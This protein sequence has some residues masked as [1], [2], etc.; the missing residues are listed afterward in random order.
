MAKGVL[1]AWAESVGT[2]VNEIAGFRFTRLTAQ[3]ALGD[4]VF[5]VETTFGWPSSGRVVCDGTVFTYAAKTATSLTGIRWDDQAQRE[6]AADDLNAVNEQVLVSLSG[7]SVVQVVLSG[8]WVGTI[9]LEQGDSV[10][11]WTTVATYNANA[12]AEVVVP[13]GSQARLRVSAYTSGTAAASLVVV[14]RSGAK[15]KV[16]SM[17]A[18]L[19]YSRTFSALDAVRSELFVDTA[20]GPLLD[21]LGRNLGVDRPPNLVDDDVFRR[22]IKA[23]A[24]LPKGT[25]F[26]LETALTA[27]FG[28]GNFE[29]W[30]DFPTFRNTVFIRLL[31]GVN[32]ATSATGQ[33]YLMRRERRPLNV[34]AMQV[35]V[36]GPVLAVQGAR[37]ADE[38]SS[39]LQL[40]TGP[41]PEV[42]TTAKPS[43]LTE[44]RYSG[45]AGAAVW[46]FTGTTEGDVTTN[47]GNGLLFTP[48][49]GDT[50]HYGRT[51]RIRPESDARMS[52]R[53]RVNSALASG[54]AD[55]KQLNM[56]IR[57]GTRNICVGVIGDGGSGFQIG[58]VNFATGQFLGTVSPAIYQVGDWLDVEIKRPP[59]GRAELWV[60][61]ALRQHEAVSSFQST[62]LNEFRF[63]CQD[64]NYTQDI[65][66]RSVGFY[67]RTLTDYWNVF[68]SGAAVSSGTPAQ[69]DTNSGLMLLADD[70]KFIRTVGTGPNTGL[71]RVAGFVDTD[72]VDLTADFKPRAFVQS[73]FPTR[74]TVANAPEAFSYPQDVGKKLELAGGVAAGTYLITAVL[75]PVSAVALSGSF[76]EHSNMVE[77]TSIAPP[78]PPPFVTEV[79]LDWR[80][81]PN[82][83]TESGVYWELAG[84]GSFSGLTLTLR[85]NPP[86]DIPGGY[87]V[88]LEPVY[89]TVKSG[90][91]LTET[92]ANSPVDSFF[93]FY[94]PQHPFGPF[95]QYLDDLTVAG[96][97]PE[98]VL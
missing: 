33:T 16:R 93:P 88:I 58:F 3:L 73:A 59:G 64:V 60:N 57:D 81:L 10:S 65:N 74:V 94:L 50:A 71:W 11:G 7:P 6:T 9:L 49:I 82:F 62:T 38:D 63:G 31:N 77:V 2:A 87:V 84:A 15:K 44:T 48:G 4:A 54:A 40:L 96:V 14:A 51:A 61:G 52:M 78:T 92:E 80:V 95:A 22:V 98:V 91:L 85:A 75:D 30:E 20:E 28:A 23:M 13:A 97:I 55:G 29:I 8:T 17:T 42:F 12:S 39:T 41:H 46:V 90:Q 26:G 36:D 34:G 24:Y 1:E 66:I 72:R 67:S 43:A 76:P 56:H 79:D 32:L 25:M 83:Q 18:V 89:S 5:P 19:E 68:G 53:F 35:T 70:G 86:L 45:D 69:L 27:F 21:A 37:L 47:V